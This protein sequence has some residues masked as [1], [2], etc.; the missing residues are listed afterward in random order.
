MAPKKQSMTTIWIIAGV[1]AVLVMGGGLVVLKMLISD[2]GK[3]RQ[4]RIQM[5][6]VAPPPPPPPEVKEKPPEPEVKE[7]KIKQPEPEQTPQENP[8]QA[9]DDAPPGDQLGLDAD[10]SAGSDGFGLKANKGGRSIL[11]G[12]SSGALMRKYRWY[13]NIVQEEI[14]R[15]VRSHLEQNGG[16]PKKKVEVEVEIVLDRQSYLVEYK[17]VA[18]SGNH[19]MDEAVRNALSRINRFSEPLPGAMQR[20]SLRIKVSSKG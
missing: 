1:V 14:K 7:E 13:I 18:P 5:V 11:G 15:D 19:A 4:R 2:S 6:T 8:D 16:I 17:I 20:A 10:G 3:Q 9:Q 12:M